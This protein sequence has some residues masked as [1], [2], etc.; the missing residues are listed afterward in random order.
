MKDIIHL[1]LKYVLSLLTGIN[2]L[3]SIYTRLRLLDMSI[4][5]S[6]NNITRSYETT[7]KHEH[8][9]AD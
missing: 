7:Y 8:Y 9:S 5:I 4:G 6:V 1:A 3:N 2:M